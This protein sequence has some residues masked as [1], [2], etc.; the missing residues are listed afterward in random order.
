MLEKNNQ[1]E[2][3]FTTWMKYIREKY[4]QDMIKLHGDTEGMKKFNEFKMALLNETERIK[5]QS[6][7]MGR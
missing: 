1:E 5:E 6:R 7:R 2:T 3:E 4:C